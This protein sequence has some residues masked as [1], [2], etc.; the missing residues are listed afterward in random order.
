VSAPLRRETRRRVVG[1][2]VVSA[3]LLPVFVRQELGSVERANRMYRAGDEASAAELYGRAVETDSLG[4]I[5]TS[6]NLGTSL[7]FFEADS[8]KELLRRV[9]A[10]QDPATAQRAHYNLGFGQLM[11][12]E[13]P[14]APDSVIPEL[15]AAVRS[16]RQALRLDPHDQDARWNLALAI[17]R[18]ETLLP[19]GEDTGEESGSESDDEVPM[20][21]PQLARSENAPAESGPEPPDPRPTDDSGERIGPRE[22][23]REAW[24]LQDPGP[25][26]TERALQLL[27]AVE[28]DAELLLKGIL[29]SHRPDIAWW[30]GQAYPGGNW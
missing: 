23:A 18:L 1:A 22:G 3:L 17:R 24:A 4:D 11:A 13:T 12:S 16:F 29:W 19:P 6:F 15:R 27:S 14:S 30:T 9:A 20:N 7:L 10:T 5:A 26:T 25:L 28:D 2:A 21:D 8:A